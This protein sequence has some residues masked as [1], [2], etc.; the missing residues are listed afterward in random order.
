MKLLFQGDKPG[1][2]DRA[3]AAA[4]RP[5]HVGDWPAGVGKITDCPS[6]PPCIAHLPHTELALCPQRTFVSN[7][8]RTHMWNSH[9]RVHAHSQACTPACVRS[10]KCM[11]FVGEQPPP[12]EAATRGHPS[13]VA[14][15]FP[16][17]CPP[18]G[19]PRY[20]PWWVERVGPI[21]EWPI[22]ALF[23]VFPLT[24]AEIQLLVFRGP[25]N[26]KCAFLCLSNAK[27]GWRKCVPTLRSLLWG[28]TEPS[29]EAGPWLWKASRFG[30]C[31][32]V[33]SN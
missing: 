29:L 27:K 19:S 2:E 24:L 8:V 22:W 28:V 4:R 25:R 12:G 18:A 9:S 1:L 15:P 21:K 5:Q 10:R 30:Q 6:R 11:T 23:I 17:F 7:A 31:M 3:A 14:F 33:R 32:R 20:D 16:T 13:L 26:G